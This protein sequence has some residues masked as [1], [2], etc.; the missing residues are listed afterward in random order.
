MRALLWYTHADIR[1]EPAMKKILWTAGVA[2][3]LLAGCKDPSEQFEGPGGCRLQPVVHGGTRFA[4][5]SLSIPIEA[6][7]HDEAAEP[8]IIQVELH[9]DGAKVPVPQ[10]AI[11]RW[12]GKFGYGQTVSFEAP[13][14]AR[15][16]RAVLLVHHLNSIF[17]MDVPF[18]L[19]PESRSTNQWL[20]KKETVRL[21]GTTVMGRSTPR[22]GEGP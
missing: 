9:A 2:A 4:D 19:D 10:L 6:M 16:L 15:A 8:Q 1:K 13:P 20:M 17:E 12:H 14:G 5:D 11:R 21:V 18:I 3:L 22:P 7:A